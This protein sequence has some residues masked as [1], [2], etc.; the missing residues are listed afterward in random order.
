MPNL[1]EWTAA[2]ESALEE[3]RQRRVS[4][5]ARVVKAAHALAALQRDEV[6]RHKQVMREIDELVADLQSTCTHPES[7]YHGDP[8]GGR[9]S[10]ERCRWCGFEW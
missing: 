2:A 6:R 9:D 4:E 3:Q 8:S 1:N 5:K 7:D 10:F